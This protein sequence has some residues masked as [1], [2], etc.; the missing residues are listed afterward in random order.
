MDG[1][2]LEEESEFQILNQNE[3]G[4]DRKV[5]S[6]RKVADTIKSLVMLWVCS[7]SV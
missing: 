3:S 6:G 2:R 4:T 7:L 5:A 1:V